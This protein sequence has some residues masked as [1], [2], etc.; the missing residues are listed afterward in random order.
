MSSH[1]PKKSVAKNFSFKKKQN[2]LRK[3]I[4]IF[5]STSV[6]KFPDILVDCGSKKR[7]KEVKR[8]AI[9]FIAILY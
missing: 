5:F 1:S 8:E 6:C 4:K 3:E 9:R 7:K 2:K